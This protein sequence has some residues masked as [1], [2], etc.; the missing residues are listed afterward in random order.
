M[1]VSTPNGDLKFATNSLER[2]S[3]DFDGNV[4]IGEISPDQ[5]LHLTG[6]GATIRIEESNGTGSGG[7][8]QFFTNTTAQGTIRSGGS[9]GNAMAFYANGGANERMRIDVNG[10]LGVGTDT[11]GQRLSVQSS[12]QTVASF[13]STG[14]A[15]YVQLQDSTTTNPAQ[16]GTIGDN[17]VFRAQGAERMRMQTGIL[18][19]GKVAPTSSLRGVQVQADGRVTITCADADGQFPLIFARAGSGSAVGSVETISTGVQY[20]VASD[21]RLKENIEYASDSGYIIDSIQVR[22]FDWKAN[23]VHQDYGF[24]AQELNQ[25]FPLAVSQ[26]SDDEGIPWGVDN[27]KLV[28]LLVKELQELRKR[29]AELEGGDQ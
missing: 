11:A 12:G 5:L 22:Q 15:S 10:N 6:D 18:C 29:V 24:I 4:G 2:L 1:W 9:L 14:S 8:V 7:R 16:I 26:G 13:V 19:V 17:L 23:G 21:E 28:P 20:N 3:I 27:S 25:V